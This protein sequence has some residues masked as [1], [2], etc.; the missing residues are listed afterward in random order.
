MTQQSDGSC[1]ATSDSQ[2]LCS[3]FKKQPLHFRK[4]NKSYIVSK[5]YWIAH[6]DDESCCLPKCRFP[7]FFC[8]ITLKSCDGNWTYCASHIKVWDVS[9]HSSS[10]NSVELLLSRVVKCLKFCKEQSILIKETN[11]WTECPAW[12]K[13]YA[14]RKSKESFS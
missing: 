14:P 1:Y 9:T 11:E 4:Y 5:E 12:Q 13:G 10:I 7:I 2:V 8:W 6:H 3:A